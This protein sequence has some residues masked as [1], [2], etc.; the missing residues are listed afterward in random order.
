[1]EERRSTLI[2]DPPF[3]FGLILK[4]VLGGFILINLILVGTFLLAGA[5]FDTPAQ[6]LTLG[7]LVAVVEV[8]A[9][10]IVFLVVRKISHRIAGPFRRVSEVAAALQQG[11]LTVRASVRSGDYF[12]EE[13]TSLD[14]A[15]Q[16][17]RTRIQQMRESL[18][19]SAEQS[20]SSAATRQLSWF[21]T[22]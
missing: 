18:P 7:G 17:L 8:T 21:R 2:A 6:R 5:G 3:Q 10:V 13:L 11:D 1:M 20:D 9:L 14:Q 12:S 22:E 19:E 15:L 16:E 4:A